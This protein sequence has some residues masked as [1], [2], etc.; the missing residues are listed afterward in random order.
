[1]AEIGKGPGDGSD[2][3]TNGGGRVPGIVI[4]AAS[5]PPLDDTLPED[6]M[7]TDTE[8]RQSAYFRRPSVADRADYKRGRRKQYAAVVIVFILLVLI[9]SGK[10]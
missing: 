2:V 3:V 6:H 10:N 1:M 7:L 8:R 5:E 4:R 9:F